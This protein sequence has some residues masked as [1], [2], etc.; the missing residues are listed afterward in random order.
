MVQLASYTAA[1]YR[2]LLEAELSRVSTQSVVADNGWEV[3]APLLRLSSLPLRQTKRD[4]G[5]PYDFRSDCGC[6]FRSTRLTSAARE[7]SGRT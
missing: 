6:A 1:F 3:Y 4:P 2:V 5:R 7:T